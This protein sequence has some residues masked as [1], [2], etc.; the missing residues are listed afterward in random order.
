MI[1]NFTQHKLTTDQ[2]NAGV[3]DLLDGVCKRRNALL[4]FEEIPSNED[5]AERAEEVAKLASEVGV[6]QVMIGGA[7]YFMAYLET[8]LYARGITP[9]H[10]FTKR[11]ATEE[12]DGKGG[13]KKGQIFVHVG[14]VQ[15]RRS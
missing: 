2:T 7:P 6:T 14:F 4:T 9:Y 8:A 15:A 11:V 13:V 5:L 1:F 10:A 12:P 3:V